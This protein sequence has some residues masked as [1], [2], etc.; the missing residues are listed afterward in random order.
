MKLILLIKLR[1]II[2]IHLRHMEDDIYTRIKR[3]HVS[4]SSVESLCWFP[5]S[6][7]QTCIN[8]CDDLE[9]F[10]QGCNTKTIQSGNNFW[11]VSFSQA[12]T[13]LKSA[14]IEEKNTK[15][16]FRTKRRCDA[17]LILLEVLRN[18][19]SDEASGKWQPTSRGLLYLIMYI[20]SES[21][22]RCK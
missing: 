4:I 5:W 9:V 12:Q 19:T 18:G 2:L 8:Q 13:I 1:V 3:P 16:L 20:S 7:W 21:N 6:L 14:T 15:T 17:N 22:V 11:T 10:L